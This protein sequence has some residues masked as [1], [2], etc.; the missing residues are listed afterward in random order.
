MPLHGDVSVQV[1]QC[2]VRLRAIRPTV[3][4][5]DARVSVNHRPTA[6]S[7]TERAKKTK[8]AEAADRRIPHETQNGKRRKK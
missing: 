8:R 7:R 4:T 5:K 1:V 6:E 2:A 3:E